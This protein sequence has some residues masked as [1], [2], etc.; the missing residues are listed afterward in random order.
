MTF[1]PGLLLASI[2]L[3]IM[4]PTAVILAVGVSLLA[5]WVVAHL[6]T[7]RALEE[8]AVFGASTV[9]V[10]AIIYAVSL[11]LTLI[12]AFGHFTAAQT[13]VQREAATLETLLRATDAFDLPDQTTQRAHMQQAVR[14]YARAVVEQEWS[15]TSRGVGSPHVQL[16]LN[17]LTAAFLQSNPKTAGQETLHQNM[18]AWVRDIGELRGLRLTTVSRSLAAMIW[19]VTLVGLG[20]A[21][22]FPPLL[23][24]FNRGIQVTLSALLSTF[25]VLHLVVALHLAYPFTGETAISAAA[26]VALSQ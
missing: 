7:P 17:E 25:L 16:R 18:V 10:T 22:L 9:D 12:G 13:A 8:N 11:A 19:G 6:M 1:D 24:V 21:L 15:S 23:G 2:P 26:L 5:S 14:E 3:A 4:I 20:I